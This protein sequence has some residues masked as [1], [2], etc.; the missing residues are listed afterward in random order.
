M[1]SSTNSSFLNQLDAIRMMNLPFTL[2]QLIIIYIR[3]VIGTPS[4]I[5]S[6]ANMISIFSISY[7]RLLSNLTSVQ[8]NYLKTTLLNWYLED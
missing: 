6:L 2:R 1:I 7:L 8:S 4:N 5:I 3:S